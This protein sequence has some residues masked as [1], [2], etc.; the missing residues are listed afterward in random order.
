VYERPGEPRLVSFE[1]NWRANLAAIGPANNTCSVSS[2]TS[3]ATVMGWTKPSRRRP[4]LLVDRPFHQGASIRWT[5]LPFRATAGIEQPGVLKHADGAFD[6]DRVPSLLENGMARNQ[7][8]QGS[9]L[10]AASLHAGLHRRE[11][12]SGTGADQLRRRSL[13]FL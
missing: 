7:A 11:R 8:L 9:R 10:G 1:P 13:A 5:Q 6:C 4:R 3:L 2:I 12:G